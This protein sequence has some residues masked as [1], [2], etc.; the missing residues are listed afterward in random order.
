MN[1]SHYL[2]TVL[3]FSCSLLIYKIHHSLQG[4]CH[5]HSISCHTGNNIIS[6][7]SHDLRPLAPA[8]AGIPEAGTTSIE[9]SFKKTEKKSTESSCNT[10]TPKASSA[11][12]CIIFLCSQLLQ[13]NCK[14][15]TC[16]ICTQDQE[17]GSRAETHPLRSLIRC[18]VNKAQG[19]CGRVRATQGI[20]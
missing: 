1:P 10:Q 16:I 20:H 18:T 7:T 3:P 9:A 4:S 17:I 14:P 11:V 12:H 5:W 19:L 2:G 15:S 8:A 13:A 6:E